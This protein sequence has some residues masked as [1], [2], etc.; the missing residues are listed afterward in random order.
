[1]ALA[2]CRSA[3]SVASMH[4]YCCELPFFQKIIK[5]VKINTSTFQAGGNMK[6]LTILSIAFF[7]ASCGTVGGLVSGAG[8][9]LQKAGEWIKK[10]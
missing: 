2:G 4:I 1:M 5:M 9:D 7:L 6:K 3:Q 10:K 8:T